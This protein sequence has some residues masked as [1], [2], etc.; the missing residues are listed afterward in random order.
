MLVCAAHPSLREPTGPIWR[1]ASAAPGPAELLAAVEAGGR[2]LAAIA[3]ALGRQLGL[4]WWTSVP[5]SLL[6]A[7]ARDEGRPPVLVIDSL[8]EADDTGEVASWLISLASLTR[9][10]G[11]TAARL[12]VGTRAYE[13]SA[14]LRELAAET[15]SGCTTLTLYPAL[16]WKTI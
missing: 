15:S 4:S 6:T 7:L 5:D 2:S 14:A 16:C 10:D 8:D 12:L 1:V 3:D 13:E 11:S 9:P